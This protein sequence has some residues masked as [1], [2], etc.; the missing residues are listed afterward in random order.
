M[1]APSSGTTQIDLC[2]RPIVCQAGKLI[3][4]VTSYSRNTLIEIIEL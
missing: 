1:C 2:V 3:N 4:F